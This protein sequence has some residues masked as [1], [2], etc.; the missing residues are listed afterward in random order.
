MALALAMILPAPAAALDALPV[1]QLGPA[2][3]VDPARPMPA[4]IPLRLRSP[5]EYRTAKAAADNS[6][7]RRAERSNTAPR[8]SSSAP[9]SLASTTQ[10]APGLDAWHAGYNTPPD[11][12]GAIG[13]NN[14]VELVNSQI[15]VYSRSSPTAPPLSEDESTFVGTSFGTCDGQIQW[16]QQAGR[17]L[18]SA[19]ACDSNDPNQ[20]LFFG[21]SK[22]ADPANLAATNWCRYA[23]TTDP[24]MEDYPKLGHDDTQII[25][26]ANEFDSDENYLRS[27]V[28]V[29]DKPGPGTL[30]SCPDESAGELYQALAGSFTPVPA[31]LADSSTTGYVVADSPTNHTQTQIL[32]YRIGRSGGANAVIDSTAIAVPAFDLPAN[33]PQPAPGLDI[34]S[35]DARLTQ[36]VATTDPNTH[37][38]GIWTQHTV[39]GS[40]GPSVVRWYELTP[41]S[42]T[43]A[44]TGT[45]TGPNG[46]FVFNGAIS[47]TTNGSGAVIFYNSGDGSHLVDLRAQSRLASMSAGQMTADLQLGASSTTDTDFSCTLSVDEPCRWG[48]YAGASPDPSAANLVWGTGELTTLPP[49]QAGIPQWGTINAAV[50]TPTPVTAV[51]SPTVH[52]AS[53][54]SG[55][56]YRLGQSVSTSFG[57]SEGTGG[58]GLSSC[59][60][61]NG[62]SGPSGHLV[63]SRTGTH[64]YRVTATSRSGMTATATLSYSVVAPVRVAILSRRIRV[65][66]GAAAVTLSCSG[67]PPAAVCR[68]T[69]SI[70]TRVRRRVRRRIH[71]HRRTVTITTTVALAK[72]RYATS[73]GLREPTVLTLTPKGLAMVVHAPR[74]GLAA[75]V[76]ATLTGAAATHQPITLTR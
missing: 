73:T 13:P 17:W 19:I 74:R 64:T 29:F 7:R 27:T 53:P 68:G 63:T 54:A 61:S 28:F 67:G 6:Q 37:T 1:R 21:F 14:Y 33:V 34:D 52:I 60:D 23:V 49:A 71:G 72:V 11:T 66:N 57:C 15:A 76:T 2:P 38:E 75:Q 22:T 25:I 39:A 44:Q 59:E 26:G 42:S 70:T 31:N 56:S 12:T 24:V 41:G 35:A 8:S 40:A 20:E 30:T 10:T 5:A 32:L 69:L 50:S 3:G 58:P 43:P 51:S 65:R 36:A 48:D 55:G 4:P 18:Y 9:L 47:P 46:T 62:S 16:D 45:V